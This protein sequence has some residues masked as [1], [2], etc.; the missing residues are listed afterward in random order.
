MSF[1]GKATY[2]AGSN[3]PELAE[4][5]SDIVSIVTPYETALL[6]HL[7]DPPRAASGTYHEWLEDEMLPRLIASWLMYSK[8]LLGMYITPH[9]PSGSIS[10]LSMQE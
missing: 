9:L 5:V 8:L 4:D 2:G 1:T 10:I 6:D 7:G 3:L